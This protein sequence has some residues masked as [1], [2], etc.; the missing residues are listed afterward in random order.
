MKF[1]ISD[2]V[3]DV[4]EQFVVSS[5][6]STSYNS[7]GDPTYTYTE[8]IVSGVVQV[9]AGDEDE[10]REGLLSKEDLIVYVDEDAGFADQITKEDTF[11]VSSMVSGI[12][13]VV[14]VI[15]NDGHYEYQAKRIVTL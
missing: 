7:R 11:V 4:G 3:L 14:G 13:R 10:V 12:F 1:D 15:H 2:I 5:V 8:S 6:T 9:M